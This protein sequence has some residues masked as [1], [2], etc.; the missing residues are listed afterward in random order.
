MHANCYQT[1]HGEHAKEQL[2]ENQKT[3][4]EMHLNM[5]VLDPRLKFIVPIHISNYISVCLLH[6]VLAVHEVLLYYG[7]MDELNAMYLP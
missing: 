3:L 5:V 7:P 2:L 4:A 1:F 6:C